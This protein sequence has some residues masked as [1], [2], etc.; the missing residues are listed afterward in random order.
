MRSWGVVERYS[1]PQ[2]FSGLLLP[3]HSKDVG[4][5]QRRQHLTEESNY[6]LHCWNSSLTS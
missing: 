1:Q 5:E 6:R 3:P 4:P 2:D